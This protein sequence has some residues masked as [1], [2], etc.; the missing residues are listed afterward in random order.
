MIRCA[1]ASR[2]DERMSPGGTAASARCEIPAGLEIVI[3]ADSG[4]SAS[5]IPEAE[6][7]DFLSAAWRTLSGSLFSVSLAL[8][9][10]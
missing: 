2:S 5:T 3:I 6:G 7:C 10:H 1:R 9:A 8:N 4:V